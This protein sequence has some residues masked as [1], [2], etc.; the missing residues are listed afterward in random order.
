[1]KKIVIQSMAILGLLSLVACGNQI[2]QDE[3]NIMREKTITIFDAIENKEK[4]VNVI[5]KSQDEWK[6]I[7]EKDVYH[8]TRERGTERPFTGELLKNKESGIYTCSN[9]G[10]HLFVSETKYDSKTGWPS[11]YAAVSD[12]NIKYVEDNTLF[13]KRIEIVCSLCGAHL[14]HVFDDGPQPTGKR[15]CMNSVALNFINEDEAK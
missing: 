1:M 10:N 2:K 15:Y 3:N 14:G 13:M 9:C 8:V 7:L 5:F 4:T 6:A 11:F 12:K